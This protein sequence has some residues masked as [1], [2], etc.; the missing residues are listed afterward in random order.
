VDSGKARRSPVDYRE[1]VR[2][3]RCERGPFHPECLH[4]QRSHL[5]GSVSHAGATTQGL[6]SQR[7]ASS[8]FGAG[9]GNSPPHQ[10]TEQ[11]QHVWRT[12]P[13]RSYPT[14]R[15]GLGLRVHEAGGRLWRKH[16]TKCRRHPTPRVRAA[17]CIQP[18]I[19]V[20]QP[21][22]LGDLKH[23]WAGAPTTPD[24]RHGAMNSWWESRAGHNDPLQSTANT[25]LTPICPT[26]D[27][28]LH[29]HSPVHRSNPE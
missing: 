17:T 5:E 3:R 16:A 26:N 23:L 25:G 4:A 8:R 9:S 22:E 14:Q 15:A 27:R 29:P 11:T 10:I 18:V 21:L 12:H 6:R 24:A 1:P 2:L 28:T 19:Y 7:A 20:L 13:E